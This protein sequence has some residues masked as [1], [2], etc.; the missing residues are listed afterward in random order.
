MQATNHHDS[1]RALS[2]LER[3]EAEECQ[4]SE[5]TWLRVNWQSMESWQSAL[6]LRAS[7]NGI[8]QSPG[9][10]VANPPVVADHLEAGSPGD[11]ALGLAAD[12]RGADPLHLSTVAKEATGMDFP[13]LFASARVKKA[14]N[15]LLNPNYDLIEIVSE[16]GFESLSD[17]SREF[18]SIVGEPPRAYRARLPG[19]DAYRIPRGA[20]TQ[21]DSVA[22]L[23]KE[24]RRV[25]HGA[26]PGGGHSG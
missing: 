10:E 22:G 13:E 7:G 3:Y 11:L 2:V 8:C 18:T 16:L 9:N 6:R 15:L 1:A 23:I 17:F 12:T 25:F 24:D 14:K 20:R 21:E 5:A 19:L 4:T 26:S